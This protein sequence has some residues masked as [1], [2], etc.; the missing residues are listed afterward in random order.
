M[1]ALILAVLLLLIVA[2]PVIVLSR[3]AT[4]RD[5][6]EWIAELRIERWR[7]RATR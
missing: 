5:I 7:R 1:N 3:A 2:Q 6:R 4:K